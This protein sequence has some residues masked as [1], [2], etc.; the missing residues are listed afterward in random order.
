MR[1][2]AESPT[3]LRC[4]GHDLALSVEGHLPFFSPLSQLVEIV[5]HL[6]SVVFIFNHHRDLVTIKTVLIQRAYQI[7]WLNYLYRLLVLKWTISSVWK[8]RFKSLPVCLRQRS[9]PVSKFSSSS[10]Y[11]LEVA[12]VCLIVGKDCCA[13][14]LLFPLAV[15]I[16]PHNIN[17]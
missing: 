4:Y 14:R 17:L 16:F 1:G 12:S 7:L 2:E 3:T 5:L 15:A 6:P 11:K 13:A 8:Y 10:S 9:S